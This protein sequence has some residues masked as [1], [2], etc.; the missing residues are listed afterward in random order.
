MV[1][2]YDLDQ[3]FGINLYGAVRPATLDMD[4]LMSGPFYWI[5][6][7][8]QEDMRERYKELRDR[9]VFDAEFI[10]RIIDDWYERVGEEYYT[11]EK[12]QWPNSP[13]YSDAVCS[14]GWKS[15]ING[16]TT[17]RRRI[18]MRTNY[19]IQATLSNWRADYGKPPK[20]CKE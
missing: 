12:A 13:C 6:K 8:Y 11:M 5:H 9:G 17:L 15:I 16:Q 18:T 2:P 10:C 7:Y 14:Q 1:T 20:R 3:T 4:Y 19:T